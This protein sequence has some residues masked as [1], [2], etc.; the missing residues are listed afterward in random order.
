M[1]F[2]LYLLIQKEDLHYITQQRLKLKMDP[3]CSKST[4]EYLKISTNAINEWINEL[5]R[6]FDF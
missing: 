1:E 6:Q 5:M 4:K 2:L 3:N